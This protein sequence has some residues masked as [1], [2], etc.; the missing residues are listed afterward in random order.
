M[1]EGWKLSGLQAHK[2]LLVTP[3]KRWKLQN[4]VLSDFLFFFQGQ[5]FRAHASNY[6]VRQIV[7]RNDAEECRAPS[8]LRHFRGTR[9]VEEEKAVSIRHRTATVQ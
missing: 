4:P 8:N 2:N 9:G 7:I 1:H 6:L 3:S 5:L